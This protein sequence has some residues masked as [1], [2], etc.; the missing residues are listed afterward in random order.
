MAMQV[1]GKTWSVTCVSMG[2][3]HAIVYSNSDGMVKVRLHVWS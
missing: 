1:A 3:P 2:N